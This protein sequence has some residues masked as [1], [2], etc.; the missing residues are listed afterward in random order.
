ME[1]ASATGDAW[2]RLTGKQHEVLSLV[3]DR[4]SNKEI[5]RLLGISESGVEQRLRAAMVRLGCNRRADA[6]RAY[7]AMLRTCGESTGAKLHLI[8]SPDVDQSSGRDAHSNDVLTLADSS[9]LDWGAAP[10]V[11]NP[12]ES[13][14]LGELD[15]KFGI[16]GRIVMI[17]GLSAT[18]ALLLLAMLAIASSLDRIF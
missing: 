1:R 9:P 2:N 7:E 4:R 17:V 18:M 13:A 14:L 6:A 12:N 5:S 15:R 10:W 8:N 3:V 11:R 16:S